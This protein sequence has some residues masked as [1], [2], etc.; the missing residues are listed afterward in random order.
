MH[1]DEALLAPVR[2]RY[3]TPAAL[4]WQGEISDAEWAIA[5]HDPRRTHDVT[6]VILGRG[7]RPALIRALWRYRVALHDLALAQL[8]K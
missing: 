3:G 5:T 7:Q 6:L 2:E 1:V 4:E 8:D